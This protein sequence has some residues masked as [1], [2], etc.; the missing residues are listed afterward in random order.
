MHNQK[1][2]SLIE[3]M[4]VV[5]IIGILAAIGYPSYQDSV[6]K[7]RRADCEGALVGFSGAMER[8]FTTMNS[9]AGAGPAGADTGAP[10]IYSTQCPIDGGT[11]SYNLTI[12]A[13]TATTYTL[14]ATPINGQA[15]DACGTLTL[16]Q[17]NVKGSAGTVA[18][19][20]E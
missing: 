2:F 10:T 12:Q 20:W 9:Y 14:A 13:S 18:D 11:P 7:S 8:R 4:I 1:G 5:A 16:T 3:L 19:C 17:A 15:S 6:Q